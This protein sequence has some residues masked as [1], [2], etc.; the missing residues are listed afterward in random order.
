MQFDA[1]DDANSLRLF[2]ES[3]EGA[4]SRNAPSSLDHGSLLTSAL[5]MAVIQIVF[6]RLPSQLRQNIGR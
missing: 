3:A 4:M 5:T 2:P 1:D 6:V